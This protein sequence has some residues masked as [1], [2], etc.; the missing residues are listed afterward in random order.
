MGLQIKF[1]IDGVVERENDLFVA[2][3]FC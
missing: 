1:M 3:G 2:R